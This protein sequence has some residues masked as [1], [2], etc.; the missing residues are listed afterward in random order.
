M[1]VYSPAWYNLN[2]FCINSAS[3]DELHI[4]KIKLDYQEVG[5][6]PSEVQALWETKL[7]VPCRTKVQWDK[8]EIHN[9]L[10][11]G[12]ISKHNI[13]TTHM[14]IQKLSL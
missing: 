3:R 14:I 2:A 11:Q 7:N 13:S 12:N 4:R 1:A 6:Y 5:E 8:D 9:A 10:C